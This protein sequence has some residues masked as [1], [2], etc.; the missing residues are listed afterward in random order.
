LGRWLE[1][2]ALSQAAASLRLKPLA[3]FHQGLFVACSTDYEGFE[4]RP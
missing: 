2:H 3:S 1:A 4:I